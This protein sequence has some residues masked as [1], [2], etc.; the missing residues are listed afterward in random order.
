MTKNQVPIFI[1]IKGNSQRCPGK[2][3]KL[4]PFAYNYLKRQFLISN[5]IVISEAQALL[6]YAIS[7]G[8]TNTYK[9]PFNPKG[10]ENESIYNCIN[11]LHIRTNWVILFPVCQ[12]LKS[13]NLIIDCI[14]HISPRYDFITSYNIVADRSIFLLD[15]NNK[16]VVDSEERKGSLCKQTKMIDGAIYCIKYSF[17]EKC[18]KSENANKEFWAGNF[19]VVKNDTLFFDIDTREDMQQFENTGIVFNEKK[20]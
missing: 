12:P 6:D 14:S 5:T 8:F 19:D 9:E 15:D 2:N 20:N 18:V 7:L 1:T 11:A 13:D 10:S 3:K 4:L 16:F 17:L